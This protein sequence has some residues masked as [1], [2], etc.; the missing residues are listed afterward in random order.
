MVVASP[1]IASH[2]ANSVYSGA[3]RAAGHLENGLI[4]AYFEVGCPHA[5]LSCLMEELKQRILGL[6]SKHDTHDNKQNLMVAV[7]GSSQ[8]VILAVLLAK[9]TRRSKRF[10]FASVMGCM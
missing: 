5:H 4:H 10:A 9:R 7:L 1:A 6:E 2:H 8:F 3:R